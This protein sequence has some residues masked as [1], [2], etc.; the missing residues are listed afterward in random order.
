ML[1]VDRGSLLTFRQTISPLH[2]GGIAEIEKA[3]TEEEYGVIFLDTLWRA[4]PG[5]DTVKDGALFSDVLG[6]LQEIATRVTGSFITVVQNRKPNG[7]ASF[8]PVDDVC[9]STG[10]VVAADAVIGL[11]IE[12]GKPG[13]RLIGESRDSEPF[14]WKIHLDH[15]TLCWQLDGETDEIKI[16]DEREAILGVLA[17][18]GKAQ[19]ATIAKTIGADYGNTYRKMCALWTAGKVHKESIE[20]KDYYCLPSKDESNE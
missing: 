16:S 10:L 3:F 17:E 11:Y 19:T 9:G 15:E 12:Q 1:G 2:L 7:M 20:G 14:D 18:L 13:A 5:K 4:M 6:K 8:Q